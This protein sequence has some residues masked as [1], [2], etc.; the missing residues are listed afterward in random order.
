M[1]RRFFIVEVENGFGVQNSW[2]EYYL[3]PVHF[4]Q[5]MWHLVPARP[6]GIVRMKGLAVRKTGIVVRRKRTNGFKQ[7]NLL[8]FRNGWNSPGDFESRQLS[9]SEEVSSATQER[10]TSPND[11]KCSVLP[12]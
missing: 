6:P 2:E 10:V 3:R 4:M 8:V 7:F 9:A 1:E 11:K 5:Q 12:R